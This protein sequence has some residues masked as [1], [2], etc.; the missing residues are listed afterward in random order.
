MKSHSK[1]KFVGN[2]K[3]DF[4]FDELNEV[5]KHAKKPSEIDFEEF[6]KAFMQLD[7]KTIIQG[8]VHLVNGKPFIIPEPEPS[9]LYFTN[10]ENKLSDLLKIQSILLSS[11]L[12]TTN[13][14]ELSHTFYNFFQLSSDYILNLFTSIEAFNNSMIPDDFIIKI[15]RKTFDKNRTLRSMDFLTKI[16]K[17]MPK[18]M[19]KSFLKDHPEKYEFILEIKNLRDNV[20]HTKD[21]QSGFPAS[22]RELYVSYLNFDFSKSYI[23]TKD[24]F[25]YYQENWIEECNCEK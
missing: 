25:N 22:Y 1:R 5:N 20:V 15:K 11:N 4:K 17:A 7:D 6:S 10:A 14:T 23:I 12:T 8:F 3:V 13:F 9:I 21:M 24:Y 19:N 2:F 18:I 16:K